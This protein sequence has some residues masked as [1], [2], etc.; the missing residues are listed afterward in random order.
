MVLERS[1]SE[2]G[3]RR[4]HFPRDMETPFLWKRLRAGKNFGL[5]NA[6]GWTLWKKN[7]LLQTGNGLGLETAWRWKQPGAGNSRK[8]QTSLNPP[9]QFATAFS[10]HQTPACQLDALVQ[11]RSQ[12]QKF[13]QLKFE[14]EKSMET[15]TIISRK[16]NVPLFS[17]RLETALGWKQPSAG[18]SFRLA[19]A[20]FEIFWNLQR[21][22]HTKFCLPIHS[23]M[24]GTH[25]L[26]EIHPGILESSS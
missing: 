1:L 21:P 7:Y 10:K 26:S 8:I 15:H 13:F 24:A 20:A 19:T 22:T 25:R 23:S 2:E 3:S 6:L 9:Q 5:D 16:Q 4:A 14:G 17:I 12:L 11:L 18:K